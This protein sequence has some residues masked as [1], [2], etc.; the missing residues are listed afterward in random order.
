MVPTMTVHPIDLRFQGKMGLIAA[1]LVEGDDG[2]LLVETGPAS[3][4]ETLIEGLRERG[5]EPE[6]L[7]GVF[8]THIHLDHAGAA[9]WFASRGVPLH[10]HP[11]GVPHLV[12]PSRLV[13]SA[14]QVYGDRFDALWGETVPAPEER[15]LAMSDGEKA[16]L[17][18]IEVEAVETPGHARHH[19]AFRIG[20]VVFTG[21]A[22]GASLESSG[23]LSV[24]ERLRALDPSVLYLTHFGRI[25]APAEHL[26][27]YHEAVD[28]AAA[29]V[30]R[31]LAEGMDPESLRI[32][33]EVFQL[34]QAYR[35]EVPRESWSSYQLANAAGMCAD[36]IRLYWERLATAGS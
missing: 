33:Y 11:A 7:A 27:R 21:D 19:H 29:F 16:R 8:V 13:A 26:A 4:L 18:G 31:R 1:Y 20:G 14:R 30:E 25:D 2:S 36:G 35:Y 34:E 9:G 24:T 23:Y 10:V 32:A 3:T 12:D 28:L 15:V 6:S 22:A 17:G 5:C